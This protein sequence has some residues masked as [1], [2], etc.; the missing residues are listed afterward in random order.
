MKNMLWCFV[1]A[2]MIPAVAADDIAIV[3]AQNGYVLNSEGGV[4]LTVPTYETM[5]ATAR[6]GDYIRVQTRG[7]TGRI[8][9][10]QVHL[11]GEHW[12][13]EAHPVLLS[14]I[15]SLEK[16]NAAPLA[17]AEP[18]LTELMRRSS[19]FLGEDAPMSL[20]L[21]S[22]YAA[23][24]M[25]AGRVDEARDLMREAR[26]RLKQLELQDHLVAA[27]VHNVSGLVD[28]ARG[29]YTSA[30]KK[31]TTAM[32]ITS[33]LLGKA[34]QDV[35]V[36]YH[37]RSLAAD[38]DE[39]SQAAAADCKAANVI[40]QQVLPASAIEHPRGLIELA[41]IYLSAEQPLPA[42]SVSTAALG[43]LRTWHTD[44]SFDIAVCQFYLGEGWSMREQYVE[45]ERWHNAINTSL[46]AG[47]ADSEV[48]QMLN[49]RK[50]RQQA[51]GD[52]DFA[53]ERFA[54]ALQH[55]VTAAELSDDDNLQSID[56]WSYVYAADALAELGQQ[57]KSRR[58]YKGA[59]LIFEKT[60]GP[61]S[62]SAREAKQLFEDAGGLIAENSQPSTD[63][64]MNDAPVIDSPGPDASTGP[65]NAGSGSFIQS[66]EGMLTASRQTP[67]M[68]V[69]TVI[70]TV[71][72]GT[73]L[74]SLE[75]RD[76]WHRVLVPGE[77]RT[78]WVSA[79]NVVSEH[80]T[81][82]QQTSLLINNRA[83]DSQAAGRL[84]K[85]VLTLL[86][87]IRKVTQEQGLSASIPLQ[88]ELVSLLQEAVGDDHYLTAGARAQLAGFY[89]GSRQFLKSR[90][91]IERALPSLKRVYGT[92][93]P[94]VAGQ[95]STLSVLLE[96]IGDSPGSEDCLS[97]ATLI[98][99][100]HFS[101][102]D[103]RLLGLRV[104]Q[105]AALA[106]NGRL[107]Q[108]A[109]L[110]QQVRELAAADHRNLEL[111]ATY[112]AGAV[113]LLQRRYAEGVVLLQE[114]NALCEQ[115]GDEANST[116]GMV[117]DALAIAAFALGDRQQ[118][119]SHACI[120]LAL[121]ESAGASAP[122][123]LPVQ[124]RLAHLEQDWE[125]LLQLNGRLR[126]NAIDVFG[127]RSVK[128][129]P[130]WTGH[131]GALAQMERYEEA[132]N[133]FDNARRIA[134]QHVVNVIADLSVSK[135]IAFLKM[136]D[137]AM[138]HSALS[139]GLKA[140]EDAEVAKASATWLLNSKNVANELAA[141]DIQARR[142]CTA[143]R[144]LTDYE[145][146][147]DG[148]RRLATL[149][150]LS[151]E[152]ATDNH[153][154]GTKER[155]QQT[156]DGAFQR[157]PKALQQLLISRRTPWVTCDEIRG[158]LA[159]DEVF[160]DIAR[161]RK[162]PYGVD[163][164][165]ITDRPF[166]YAAWIVPGNPERPVRIVELGD[167]EELESELIKPF[168]KKVMTS[169][170]KIKTVGED[171]ALV[172]MAELNRGLS[173]KIWQPIARELPQGTTRL[174]LCPD[175]ALWSIPWAAIEQPSRKLVI[176]DFVI[177][178][179]SSGRDLLR[180]DVAVADLQPP[181]II[182]DPAYDVSAAEID[183]EPSEFRLRSFNFRLENVDATLLKDMLPR[184]V[185]RL[186]ATAGEA[187]AVAPFLNQYSGMK[188]DMYLQ[189]AASET[190]LRL[191]RR[192]HTLFVG[193]HG[194]FWEEEQLPEGPV[195]TG[196]SAALP[197]SPE[198]NRRLNPLRRCGLL[199]AGC[200]TLPTGAGQ[201]KLDGI[202]TGSEIVGLDLQ[203]TKLVVMSACETGVGELTSG[204][205]VAGLRQA[206]QLAGAECVV[207]TLWKIP[208]SETKR[209][210]TAYFEHLAAGE[211]R[212]T[213]LRLAQLD[214][215]RARRERNGAAHP[216]FWAA[217]TVT[218]QD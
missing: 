60:D 23:K 7:T 117:E 111:T 88:L 32:T 190:A 58:L 41:Q 136:T 61:D 119:E 87:Q 196:R 70:T 90:D 56:G 9:K 113:R 5:T 108:S 207:S 21:Q 202:V 192:P 193:T 147:L 99:A 184:T 213:A 131:G 96:M 191:T 48:A 105:A 180:E 166:V 218:G 154:R 122:T 209:L 78:A 132:A 59:W 194:F 65:A 44:R 74:W 116:R 168:L 126:D 1:A 142:L 73:R 160:I 3:T 118:A 22:V 102:A 135:Q 100:T 201:D 13:T 158:Q 80:F 137:N 183:D 79:K 139:M 123:L 200:S 133:S 46:P 72:A 145:Q 38:L 18:Q 181:T 130:G 81:H 189:K 148:R 159:A 163:A 84:N 86:P 8:H 144:H 57:Q 157:L 16:A 185:E 43:L 205:G 203:G 186:K 104:R 188:P 174:T 127:P 19:E 45:A 36:H 106:N 210:M 162:T 129:V 103:A 68:D 120:S 109:E 82:A 156:V 165:G 204:Q 125:Q 66:G 171:G 150:P 215:I 97:Q 29:K 198:S 138:L 169:A 25:E 206:M 50:E 69:S 121:L 31:F 71:P 91:V 33:G 155:L 208:D 173:L 146:W 167:A 2:L 140:A 83:G 143:D 37:N 175:S 95:L 28:F 195:P 199:L 24:L 161:L 49:L 4:A 42:I 54:D 39:D 176:E 12:Q 55:Y 94:V 179:V 89:F 110:Y 40:Y 214:R 30:R 35:A 63:I 77:D 217:F 115:M 14:M 85:R 153:L 52:I 92:D 151:D 134:Q 51:L 124:T 187:M 216:F 149:P 101:P 170:A 10:A 47:T 114:A 128:T 112:G 107:E 11:L 17:Q 177:R 197:D 178:F 182:A 141:R 152:E 172:D 64:A 6:V 15:D 98:A 62:A 20:V 75:T 76:E 26:R 212:A 34:H 164:A 211:T 93:H 67:I 27:E 53:R